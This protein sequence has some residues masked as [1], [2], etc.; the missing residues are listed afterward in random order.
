M[1]FIAELMPERKITLLRLA[2]AAVS[3]G[4]LLGYVSVG[5]PLVGVYSAIYLAGS[6]FFTLWLAGSVARVGANWRSD[7][8]IWGL[9]AGGWAALGLAYL[10][11]LVEAGFYGGHPAA[12]IFLIF[13]LVFTVPLGLGLGGVVGWMIHLS[14]TAAKRAT[15]FH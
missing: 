5:E 8:V 15:S 11:G 2:V 3:G 1:T 14:A 4:V 7:A 10:A 13:A 6:T 12:F 9:R